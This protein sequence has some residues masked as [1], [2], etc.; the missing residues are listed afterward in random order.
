MI[1]VLVLLDK[2]LSERKFFVERDNDA[3]VS[4][5]ETHLEVDFNLFSANML[6]RFVKEKDIVCSF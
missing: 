1:V 6:D 3:I 2:Y 4:F 5:L